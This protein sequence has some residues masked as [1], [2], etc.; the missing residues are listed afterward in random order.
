MTLCALS[1]PASEREPETSTRLTLEMAVESAQRND[2][3]LVSSKH[4]Q[5]ALRSMSISAG[6]L[7]DPKFSVGLANLPTDTLDFD[8]EPMTQLKLGVT[9]MFPRGATLAIRRERLELMAGQ[10]PYQR[11]DRNAKTALTVSNLWLD[12]FQAQESIA[13]IEKNRALFEQL[14][15]VAQANYSSAIGRTRQQ[16]IV[17]AQLELTQLEDRL[18]KLHMKREVSRQQLS[19]WLTNAPDGHAGLSMLADMSTTGLARQL[20]ALKLLHPELYTDAD[21]ISSQDLYQQIAD[22]PALRALE[23]KVL[24]GDAEVRL[25][26]QKYRPGWGINA[27]YAYRD[28]MPGG[29]GRADFF[30]IGAT[31]D[32]PLFTTNRQD[33]DV[34]A[35]L[36]KAE[37][38]ATEKWLLTRKLIATFR[39]SKVQLIRLEQRR[40]LYSDQLMPQLRQQAE[41]SLTAYTNDDGDFAEVVRARIAELNGE[42]DIL[43]IDV[44]RL[45][46]VVELNYLFD[47][48]KST[49]GIAG[50][51]GESK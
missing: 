12:A 24:I 43:G 36:S 15:D 31:V 44:E 37:A 21:E 45:K 10:H 38:I 3:W 11:R 7:P 51:Q 32:L 29:E 6:S 1:A 47:A 50:D 46:T 14:A 20:P 17:R 9:Q 8:Q 27:G 33:R 19:E 30:S 35:A 18:T 34:E 2:P 22:H 26:R 40:A 23:Q 16:D 49:T 28:A 13:L 25:A 4:S 5:S 39:S 48:K 42:I 41:A